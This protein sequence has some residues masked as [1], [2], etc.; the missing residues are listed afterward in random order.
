MDQQI[1]KEVVV[2]TSKGTF[3]VKCPQQATVAW[4]LDSASISMA[5]G[6]KLVAART[7]DGSV[8][9]DTDHIF[10]VCKENKILFAIT[11]AET[12]DIP[13]AFANA[14]SAPTSSTLK[15]RPN[16]RNR[17]TYMRGALSGTPSSSSSSS[18]YATEDGL[19]GSR[20]SLTEEKGTSSARQSL[21]MSGKPATEPPQL[22]RKDS[23]S[24]SVPRISL[25]LDS[26]MGDL[27]V[28]TQGIS[29]TTAQTL[30]PTTLSPAETPSTPSSLLSQPKELPSRL[31][32]ASVDDTAWTLGGA[33]LEMLKKDGSGKETAKLKGDGAGLKRLTRASALE[34][35]KSLSPVKSTFP[36]DE[37]E[38]MDEEV[39]DEETIKLLKALNEPIPTKKPAW[40]ED[41][42]KEQRML[43]PLPPLG[44]SEDVPD[45]PDSP[46]QLMM[47]SNPPPPPPMP[48]TNTPPQPPMPTTN[49]STA[50]P[51]PPSPPLSV[52]APATAGI[53]LPPP[54]PPPPPM[55]T[56]T[57]TSSIPPPPPP[58]PPM[59]SQTSIASLSGPPPPPPPPPPVMAAGGPPPPPPPPPL[60]GGP[61]PPPPP[62]PGMGGPPPPPPPPP[63]M[64]GPPPPPPPAIPTSSSAPAPAPAADADPQAALLAALRDPSLRKK[65][66]KRDPPPAKPVVPVE[67]PTTTETEKQELFIEL[68]GYMEA[69]HGNVEELMEKLK[70]ATNTSRSF[71]YT[72]VRRRWVEGFRVVEKLGGHNGPPL[73]VWPGREWM[74]AREL[75][76]VTEDTIS[77]QFRQ[78]QIVSR[79]HM[80]R[81]DQK[82]KKHVM[83]QVLLLKTDEFP[84]KPPPFT[85]PEPPQDQSLEN[86]RK[87]EE[88][89]L[90]KQEYLQSPYPQFELI[91]QKLSSND[92]IVLSIHQQLDQTLSEMKRMGEA[93]QATFEGFSIRQLRKIV[94]SI[95]TRIKEVARNLQKSSGIIIRDEQLKLTPEFLKQM[96]L[97]TDEAAAEMERK[98]KKEEEEAAAAAA[99]KKKEDG[100]AETG[101]TPVIPN[102]KGSITMGGVP[103]DVLI[104]LLKKSYV[105]SQE[106]AK[107]RRLTL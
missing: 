10:D 39:P 104:P 95:P 8:A 21:N 45:L 57:S 73:T 42:D 40:M 15:D 90:L 98:K 101:G 47:G 60:M 99:G 61:P 83:D 103:L 32:R 44:P 67:D 50:P 33:H 82:H 28:L 14:F 27:E 78:D 34:V 63:G 38:Q 56:Q 9:K 24:N 49:T 31:M 74:A 36:T 94:Q 29:A 26:M 37:D 54:P 12:K 80:Y 66:K 81:F 7:A 106:E 70:T 72:L 13:P 87:W 20:E 91:F 107:L 18:S 97:V 102:P 17:K 62:P 46:P 71:V 5:S 93:L 55:T 1:H 100:A 84:V 76:D 53:S 85:L 86:R 59:L 16:R 96:N 4:T 92:V 68:L 65:L 23:S 43:P 105:V 6:E 3:I 22:L 52:S 2:V 79:V 11:E 25:A 89:N 51:P 58:P 48:T 75:R 30:S 41:E 19:S 69:P 35:F 77:S 88:W 64:G